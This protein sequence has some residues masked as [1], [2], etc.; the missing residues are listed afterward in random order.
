MYLLALI[1]GENR[2]DVEGRMFMLGKEE[3][4]RI[5]FKFIKFGKKINEEENAFSDRQD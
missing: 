5:F 1:L 2:C 3:N 4:R